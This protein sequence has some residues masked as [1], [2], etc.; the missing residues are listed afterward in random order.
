MHDSQRKTFENVKCI[1][2]KSNAFMSSLE[3]LFVEVWR[4]KNTIVDFFWMSQ[5]QKFLGW[6][7]NII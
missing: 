5:R 7:H 6:I 4:V 1:E 2:L 3:I